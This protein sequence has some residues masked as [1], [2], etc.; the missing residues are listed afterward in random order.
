[1]T[2]FP[3]SSK[4]RCYIYVN[5]FKIPLKTTPVILQDIGFVIVCHLMQMADADTISHYTPNLA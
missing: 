4:Q 3:I 5:L 1:M 2:V